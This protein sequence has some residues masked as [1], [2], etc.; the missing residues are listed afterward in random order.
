MALVYSLIF[1]IAIFLM[2][3][4]YMQRFLDWMR[5]QSLGTRDYIVEMCGKMFIETT[6]NR[7]LLYLVSASAGPFVLCFLAFLPK[8]LPGVILGLVL[9]IV[10]W[11][12]PKP[13]INFMYQS[14]VEKFNLQMVDGLNLM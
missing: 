11:K 6:P 1:G 5:F 3:Y 4:H 13:I 9:A 10:G 14:R 8:V 7:V 12:V 2:T